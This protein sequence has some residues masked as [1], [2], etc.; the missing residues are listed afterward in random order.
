MLIERRL[1]WNFHVHIY[2]RMYRET[3]YTNTR[4][5]VVNVGA[6]VTYLVFVTLG[7]I[8]SLFFVFDAF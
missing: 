8:F 5:R 2:L 3:E 4:Y 7:Y 6:N 1:N